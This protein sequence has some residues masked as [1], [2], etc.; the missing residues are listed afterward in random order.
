MGCSLWLLSVQFLVA[1]LRAGLSKNRELLKSLGGDG[2]GA[3]V[4]G[5][6]YFLSVRAE[7]MCAEQDWLDMLDLFASFNEDTGHEINEYVRFLL[8]PTRVSDSEL[9]PYY[10]WMGESY[11]LA[12]RFTAFCH[13]IDLLWRTNAV[14]VDELASWSRDVA[15]VSGDTRLQLVA[16]LAG[17]ARKAPNELQKQLLEVVDLYTTGEY[18]TVYHRSR[19]HI[20]RKPDLLE[21]YELAAKAAVRGRLDLQPP[22]GSAPPSERLMWHLFALFRFDGQSA[23]SHAAIRK[24]ARQLLPFPIGARLADFCEIYEGQARSPSPARS[25]ASVLTPRVALSI[26]DSAMAEALLRRVE[27]WF[28]GSRSGRLLSCLYGRDWTVPDEVPSSRAMRYH[29]IMLEM[30]DQP[31]SALSIYRELEGCSDDPI[32]RADA[33]TGQYRCALGVE[34]LQETADILSRAIASNEHW[35]G[36]SALGDIIGR[37]GQAEPQINGTIAWPILCAVARQRG[38]NGIDGERL[39]QALEAYLDTFGVDKPSELRTGEWSRGDAG[40]LTYLLRYIA[41]PDVLD[42]S[43]WFESQDEVEQE[44]IAV[45]RWLQVLDPGHRKTYVEEIGRLNR[46]MAMRNL[47]DKEG[48]SKIY[49]DI[50]GIRSQIPEKLFE[51]VTRLLAYAQLKEELQE[52]TRVVA[53]HID[54]DDGPISFKAFPLEMV[55]EPQS[56]FESVFLE[57]RRLFLSSNEFGLDANLSQRIRHGTLSGEVRAI[58]E[59]ESLLTAK[60]QFGEYRPNLT[61]LEKLGLAPDSMT[62]HRVVGAFRNLSKEVDSTVQ[63]ARESWIQIRTTAA[64]TGDEAERLFDFHFDEEAMGTAYHQ[65]MEEVRASESFTQRTSEAVDSFVEAVLDVL[66]K[67]TE[68]CLEGARVAIKERLGIGLRGALQRCAEELEASL[69][70]AAGVE[71]MRGGA[72]EAVRAALVRCGTGLDYRIQGIQSWFHFDQAQVIASFQFGDLIDAVQ[73][74]VEG[75]DR[76]A[77]S[78]SLPDE[79]VL[80]GG[81]FRPLWDAMFILIENVVKHSLH[82]NPPL[83]VSLIDQGD[84]IRIGLINSLGDDVDVVQLRERFPPRT[85]AQYL[86]QGGDMSRTEGG[87]GFIKVHKILCYDL[88]CQD[89]GIISSV[90]GDRSFEVALEI[91]AEKLY[92]TPT[93]R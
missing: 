85:D 37:V 45:C 24:I 40:R 47:A 52:T 30:R 53:V 36:S 67:R 66:W 5:L 86:V 90:V 63:R 33:I 51:R 81:A 77:L 55:K 11:S 58:F 25:C 12:D 56:I 32:A 59:T 20:R 26:N 3:W 7:S 19:A 44:R 39:F 9:V 84:T 80:R 73:S 34:N 78:K 89:Y 57:L 91:P 75:G 1:D 74:K 88:R 35:A 50:E 6:A 82:P 38:L 46:R 41:V 28:P 65:V 13:V 16:S 14:P 60:D 17:K 70:Q 54:A 72:M 22:S 92:D 4:S 68:R 93:D 76:I 79:C 23:A 61:W 87:T 64:E 18:E 8:D 27:S 15:A 62:S 49:V 83:D 31:E 42:S 43:I 10:L 29:A 2:A 69:A 71:Y 48:Q 21:F